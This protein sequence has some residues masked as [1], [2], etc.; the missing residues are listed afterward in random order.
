MKT[1]IKQSPLPKKGITTQALCCAK[2]SNKA[3]GCHD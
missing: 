3:V 2:L 1:L